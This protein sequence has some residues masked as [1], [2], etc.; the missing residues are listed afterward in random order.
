MFNK[1]TCFQ[2]SYIA[3]CSFVDKDGKTVYYHRAL[4]RSEDERGVSYQ[5]VKCTND[6]AENFDDLGL[7]G[8]PLFDLRGRLTSF[9]TIN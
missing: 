4:V 2:V 8:T 1:N 7:Y 5:L 6:F 9:V 3:H